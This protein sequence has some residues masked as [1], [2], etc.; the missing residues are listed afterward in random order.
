MV[1]DESIWKY[2]HEHKILSFKL[3]I[4]QKGDVSMS[5]MNEDEPKTKKFNWTSKHNQSQQIFTFHKK[6]GLICFNEEENL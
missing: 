1:E 6:V 3:S 4:S 5:S 2:T